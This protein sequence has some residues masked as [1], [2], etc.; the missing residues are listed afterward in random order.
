MRIDRD[1]RLD[2]THACEIIEIYLESSRA[3]LAKKRFG[4]QS[5]QIPFIFLFPDLILPDFMIASLMGMQHVA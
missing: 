2:S 3:A 4:T 5:A 1:S